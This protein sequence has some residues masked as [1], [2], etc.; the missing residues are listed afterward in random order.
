MYVLE[1]KKNVF[2]TCWKRKLYKHA[3][4]HDLSKF[5]PSE[6]LPYA[7]YFYISK[8]DFK[9]EFEKAWEHHYKNNPHHWEYWLDENGEPKPIPEKILWQMIADWEGMALKFGDTAQAFYLKNYKKIKLEYNT[10]M[11]LEHMLDINVSM[12][13]NY[14]HTLEGLIESCGLEWW[15]RNY[16]FF[17]DKYGVDLLEVL[18]IR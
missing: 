17:K 1:H 5:S 2:K 3:I 15:D 18:S 11:W 10:R 4:T 9:E 7:R 16:G 8:E 12:Y 6:F 14:G 13:H